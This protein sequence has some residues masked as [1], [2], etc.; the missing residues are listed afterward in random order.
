MSNESAIP[1]T[2][3]CLRCGY[4][5]HGLP[6]TVCPECGRAFDPA[7][8]ST[9]DLRLPDWRRRRKIK[10]IAFAV[11]GCI[12]L[13]VAFGPRA[14]LKGKLEFKC[15][16]CGETTTVYRWEPKPPRW[17]A[18]RFPGVNWSHNSAPP[19][20]G[21]PRCRAHSYSVSVKFDMHNGGWCSGA[22]TSGA[23]RVLTL[24]GLLTTVET[25]PDVLKHLMDPLNNG[26]QVG[27]SLV[28]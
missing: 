1:S 6:S 3:R 24:N 2:A 17:I 19:A 28:P 26:I 16:V 7:D 13:W 27:P 10:R 8:A 4:L 11:I 12:A 20:G 15:S 14:L 9:Y 23:R 25:G 18:P 22:G 5:L 21:P